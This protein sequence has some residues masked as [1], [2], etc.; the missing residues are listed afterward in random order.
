MDKRYNQLAIVEDFRQ[1]LQDVHAWFDQAARALESLESGSGVTIEKKNVRIGEILTEYEKHLASVDGVKEKAELVGRE[2]GEMDRQ[3]VQEQTDS[4]VRR[5]AEIKK[6]IDRKKQLVEMAHGGYVS[7]KK[8]IENMDAWMKERITFLQRDFAQSDQETRLAEVS[9][10]TKEAED[11]SMMLESLESKVAAV[12]GDLEAAEHDQLS[13]CL[14]MISAN[15]KVLSKLAKEVLKREST[16][17][18]DRKRLEDDFDDVSTWVQ[19]RSSELMLSTSGSGAGDTCDPLK[20][21][22]IEK[23]IAKLKKADAEIRAY[24]EK[25]LSR[26]RRNVMSVTKSESPSDEQQSFSTEL[27]DVEISFEMLKSDLRKRVADLED[28]VEPRRQFE[29]ELEAST[30]WLSKAENVISSEIRGGSGSTV[31]IATLDEHLQKFRALKKEEDETRDIIRRLVAEANAFMPTLYDPDRLTLQSQLDEVCDKMNAVSGTIKKKVDELAANIEHFRK[32][33]THIEKSVSHLGRIQREIKQL[34]R[35]IGHRVEDAE[36]VLASYEKILAD[37][38]SFKADLEELQRT[39]GANVA[40][41]KALLQQQEELIL[42]IENQMVKMRSL[43]GVRH[44][45]MELVTG[46]T[47]FLIQYTEVVKEVERSSMASAEKVRKYDEAILRIE[48][49]ETKLTLAADKGQQIAAEG[50]SHDRNKVTEQ[51]Q[52]LKTQITT[53]KRAIQNKRSEHEQY[54]ADHQRLVGEMESTIDWLHEKEAKA[55]SRPLLSTT[56]QDVEEKLSDHHQ[57]ALEIG[58]CLEKVKRLRDEAKS[59]ATPMPASVAKVLSSAS[60]LL[61]SMPND[62]ADRRQYLENNKQHRLH[63]DSL[64]ERLNSWVE[65]AQ[66]KL[67]SNGGVDFANVAGELDEHKTYFSQETQLRDLLNKIH[68]TANKIWPS[69]DQSDQDKVAHEQEFF[70]QLVK[71]TLNSA[72]SR[73]AALED[74]AKKW[75]AFRKMFERVSEMVAAVVVVDKEKPSSLAGV[76]SGIARIDASAKVIAQKKADMENY[77]DEAKRISSKADVVNRHAICEEKDALNVRLKEAM[78]ALKEQKEQLASLA[79][80]WDDFDQKCKG[81]GTAIATCHHKAAAVDSTFRSVAQMKDIKKAVKK[82]LDEAR[83]L[84][85]KQKDVTVLCKNVIKYLGEDSSD[86]VKAEVKE[87]ATLLGDKYKALLQGLEDRLQQ[88]G[89]EIG[90]LEASNKTSVDLLDKLKKLQKEIGAL[91][92]W[93]KDEDDSKTSLRVRRKI[94]KFPERPL[95]FILFRRVYA[96]AWTNTLARPKR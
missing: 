65:E 62:L 58:A 83:S 53:L 2:V 12:R 76:K 16:M 18:E 30:Q 96:S 29:S 3:N 77:N 40:E 23:R 85:S 80:Q 21:F 60:A 67:R 1:S 41:L 35:P 46:I 14:K 25:S 70:N 7:T 68:D 27:K 45:Y 79:L 93:K 57:L 5:M 37:L 43:I 75:A 32:T 91:D 8:E 42:A 59:E 39:A 82:L 71:N 54:A 36:D 34:N 4:S 9:A 73:Q 47:G 78:A 90:N 13:S 17:A 95:I 26:L 52:S 10:L 64:V 20:A 66:L 51:L 33:A 11:K 84:E 94:G 44:G 15:Q 81:F 74:H 24:E 55:K 87:T 86:T 19:T 88:V 61:Q 49:C 22:A 50:S 92:V 48:E 56:V 63:Y 89:D 28:K 38:K 69:L 72:H 6:R 31:N